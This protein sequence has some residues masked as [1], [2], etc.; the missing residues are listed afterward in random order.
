MS[1]GIAQTMK[2]MKTQVLTDF[3]NSDLD[4]ER[5]EYVFQTP[6]LAKLLGSLLTDKRDMPMVHLQLNII[7]Y[8]VP[9]VLFVYFIFMKENP[10]PGY[11]CHILGLLYVIGN[12]ILFQERFIL[13]LHFCS[14]R[15]IYDRKYPFLNSFVNWLLTP[16]YG[17]PCGVYRTHHVIMHHNENNHEWDISSTE[18]YQRDSLRHFFIYYLR[19]FLAIYVELPIYCIKAK[20]WAQLKECVMGISVWLG[21]LFVLAKF[22]SF[23]ATFYVLM[24]PVLICFLAMSFGNWS[25]HIFVDPT[26][27]TNNYALS[28]NCIDSW[29]NQ[30]TFNDGYHVIHHYNARMHWSEMPEHFHSEAAQAK[31][32]AE[33]ALTFRNIHFFDVGI[34]VMTGRLDKLAEHYVHLGPKETAPTLQAIEEKMR[35]WLKPMKAVKANAAGYKKDK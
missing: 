34:L 7:E 22:V 6:I 30:R 35:G 18:T 28:Y 19:F 23:W 32:L 27:P 10:P 8:L 1:P 31:H 25:Q 15:P 29:V 5:S 20:R 17:I 16:F 4:T 26:R 9:G 3:V 2:S 21:A 24:V 11:V 33:G 14:H 12:T 13:M